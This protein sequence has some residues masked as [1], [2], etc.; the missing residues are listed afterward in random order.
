MQTPTNANASTFAQQLA[1]MNATSNGQSCTNADDS[2]YREAEELCELRVKHDA[3]CL[4]INELEDQ[5]QCLSEEK[6]ALQSKI[7]SLQETQEL[8]SVHQEFL[9]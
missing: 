4:R 8:N 1:T 3:A 7:S 6:L 2:N 9:W 5:I